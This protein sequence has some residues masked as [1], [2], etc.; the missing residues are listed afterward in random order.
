[1]QFLLFM[2]LLSS[3][4]SKSSHPFIGNLETAIRVTNAQFDSPDILKRLDVHLLEV[5]SPLLFGVSFFFWFEYLVQKLSSIFQDNG[6]ISLIFDFL[7]F[8]VV[9]PLFFRIDDIP[10]GYGSIIDVSF[11]LTLFRDTV[12]ALIASLHGGEVFNLFLPA[13]SM[14]LFLFYA[15]R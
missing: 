11:M 14:F 5:G 9:F 1:M 8:Q 7:L 12:Y 13:V 10:F 15:L 3:F 4:F 6:I 2:M